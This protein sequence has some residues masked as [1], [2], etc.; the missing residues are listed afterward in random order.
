MKTNQKGFSVVEGLLMLVI[1]GVIGFVGWYVLSAKHQT[2]SLTGNSTQT[3]TPLKKPSNAA[4]LYKILDTE[5]YVCTKSIPAQCSG[6]IKIQDKTGKVQIVNLNHKTDFNGTD[7]A[8]LYKSSQSSPD[9]TI[10]LA[11][12]Y[13]VSIKLLSGEDKCVADY[14]EAHPDSKPENQKPSGVY[15][16]PACPEVAR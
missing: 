3:Q 5:D 14:Y 16:A 9:A 7:P 10:N 13:A 4:S 11:G 8:S 2:D 12:N 1:A 6:S 15:S